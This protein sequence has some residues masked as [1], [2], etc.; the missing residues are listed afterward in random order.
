MF[1]N[2]INII[3][4]WILM[5]NANKLKLNWIFTIQMKQTTLITIDLIL[6]VHLKIFWHTFF[7]LIWISAY[8]TYLY[9][10]S[11]YKVLQTETTKYIKQIILISQCN[12]IDC[13]NKSKLN[14]GN[15]MATPIFLFL[16][17]ACV[18]FSIFK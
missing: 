7:H 4:W 2:V 6:F 10:I 1:W 11:G 17:F 18:S 5:S 9:I 8:F 12:I 13:Q 15:F 3:S 16:R 14:Y